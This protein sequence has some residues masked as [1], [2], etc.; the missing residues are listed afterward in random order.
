M[1]GTRT[2][3]IDP[4]IRDGLVIVDGGAYL[5]RHDGTYLYRGERP[6]PGWHAHGTTRRTL[7]S[8]IAGRVVGVVLHKQRWRDVASGLTCHSRPPDDLPRVRSCSLVVVLLLW[9][10]LRSGVGL[11]RQRPARPALERAASLRTLQRWMRRAL[12]QARLTEQSLRAALIERF[13]PR[14]VESL[15]PRGPGPPEEHFRRWSDPAAASTLSRAL[16]LAVV[17]A[18]E[19]SLPTA[20]LLAVA[21]RRWLPPEKRFLL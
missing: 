6:G 20:R 2:A 5:R 10:W 1:R 21:R 19:L 7:L 11:W 17:G 13:E 16:T 8:L 3:E 15:L 9:S 12:A 18:M 4:W 14:P